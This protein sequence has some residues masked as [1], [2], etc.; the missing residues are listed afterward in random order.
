MAKD[1]AD[2]FKGRKFKVLGRGGKGNVRIRL[3]DRKTCFVSGAPATL[4]TG[5]EIE[6]T[7]YKQ[8]G[9]TTDSARYHAPQIDI[10]GLLGNPIFQGLAGGANPEH[11]AKRS[12]PAALTAPILF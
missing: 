6:I 8:G 3:P 1:I 4:K 2:K 11:A 9:G 12:K 10:T 7:D 5:D